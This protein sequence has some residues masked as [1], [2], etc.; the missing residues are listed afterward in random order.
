MSLQIVMS[1]AVE[2]GMRKAS[3]EFARGVIKQLHSGGVLTCDTET[4]VR[5]FD[6]DI[7]KS[8]SSYRICVI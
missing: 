2:N 8:L 1:A 6:F 3:V 4:A 5:M 7:G